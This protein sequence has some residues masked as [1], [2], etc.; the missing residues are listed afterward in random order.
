MNRDITTM[1]KALT[2]KEPPLFS[3]QPPPLEMTPFRR[4]TSDS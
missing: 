4:R 3:T 2:H 1:G